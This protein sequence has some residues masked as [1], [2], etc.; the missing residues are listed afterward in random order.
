MVDVALITA[1]PL[2]RPNLSASWARERAYQ[3]I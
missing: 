3:T 1:A 2:S